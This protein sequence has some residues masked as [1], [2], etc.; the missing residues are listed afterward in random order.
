M[1]KKTLTGAP[2]SIKTQQLTKIYN[3]DSAFPIKAVNEI[4][5]TIEQGE[6][7][8]GHGSPPGPAKQHF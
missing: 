2:M 1:V 6:F 8:R 4:N 3:P 5:V 7:G